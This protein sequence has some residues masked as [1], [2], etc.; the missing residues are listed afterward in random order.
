MQEHINLLKTTDPNLLM[1]LGQ[2]P[3]P[4]SQ[5]QMPPQSVGPNSPPPAGPPQGQQPA[6][7]L[8]GNLPQPT[9]LDQVGLQQK[10]PN[11]PGVDPK[12]LPNPELQAQSMANL[13]K[14]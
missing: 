13:K 10:L 4:P 8:Q 5:P 2:N 7:P 3:L 14:Q 11:V 12:L 9:Q 1:I 6:A